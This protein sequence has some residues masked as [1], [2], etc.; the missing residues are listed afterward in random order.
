MRVRARNQCYDYI[1]DFLKICFNAY[2]IVDL[3]KHNVLTLV[4]AIEVTAIII[5]VII[6]D[7]F[8]VEQFSALEQTYCVHSKQFHI[9]LTTHRRAMPNQSRPSFPLETPRFSD[10]CSW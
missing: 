6:I 5:I 4:G 7:H 10:R 2:I 1:I 3:V 9:S 8:Y